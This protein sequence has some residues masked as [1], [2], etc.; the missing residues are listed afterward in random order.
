MAGYFITAAAIKSNVINYNDLLI[1]GFSSVFLYVGGL[2]TNDLFDFD[3]D[4]KERP[5][6]PL[7]SGK[8]NKNTTIF[9]SFLFLGSGF[10]LALSMSLTSTLVSVMLVM[11]ILSYNYKLKNGVSRPFLMGSIRALNVFYGSTSNNDFLQNSYFNGSSSMDYTILVNLLIA[12]VTVF[13][14]IF[15]LT[16]I[17][18]RETVEELKKFKKIINL[19]NVYVTYLSIFIFILSLGVIFLS[20]KILFLSFFIVFL[21]A[22]T[23]IF[24]KKIKK[25]NLEPQDIQFIVKDMIILLILLDASFVTGSSGFYLGVIT[26]SLLT[27]CIIIGKKVQMT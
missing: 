4:K 12:T 23:F 14:H 3:I 19:K 11:M 5:N 2:V 1:L 16:L 15:T 10:L 13:V 24:F 18:A 21:S 20:N 8:I 22:V 6:R 9:L 27:P 7:P 26:V 17:S 25:E